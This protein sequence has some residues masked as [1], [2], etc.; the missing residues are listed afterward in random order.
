M[1]DLD[2]LVHQFPTPEAVARLW[3]SHGPEAVASRFWFM[4]E[5]ERSDAAHVGRVR[6]GWG[7]LAPRRG[8]AASAE[9]EA[10]AI[11]AAYALGEM[12][13]AE[14]AAGLGRNAI[15]AA[16][17]ARGITDPPVI[18]QEMRGL[19]T[20]D[21]RLAGEGDEAATARIEAR[22]AHAAAVYAVCLAALALVPEQPLVGRPR[23]PEPTPAL[24]AALAGFERAAVAAVFPTLPEP[25]APKPAPE[26]EPM[27]TVGAVSPHRGVPDDEQIRRCHAETPQAGKLARLWGVNESTVYSHLRRLQLTKPR[28]VVRRQLPVPAAPRSPDGDHSIGVYA[29]PGEPR[30]IGRL[31]VDGLA[32]AIELA[33]RT[34]V[35][36]LDAL[37]WVRADA[38][39]AT[40]DAKRTA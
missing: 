9:Q 17:V 4:N 33:R 35:S 1:S 10:A 16:L 3:A 34:G 40:L 23:L 12:K 11:A 20:K 21:A 24:A 19:A 13:A 38:G 27:P 29:Q 31:D 5:R 7:A 14:V 8:R 25:P 28:G 39:L 22:R 6:L 2:R 37:T 26:E 36:P 15:R 30:L 18:S 32:L